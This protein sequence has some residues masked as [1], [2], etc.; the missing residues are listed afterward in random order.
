MLDEIVKTLGKEGGYVNNSADAGGETN[1]GIS[2]RS[3][4]RHSSRISRKRVRIIFSTWK[5]SLGG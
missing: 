3:R 2:K 4:I 5:L 1:F